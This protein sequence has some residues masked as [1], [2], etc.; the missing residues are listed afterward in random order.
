MVWLD[1]P[2]GFSVSRHMRKVVPI[3]NQFLIYKDRLMSEGLMKDMVAVIAEQ[4]RCGNIACLR[5]KL[6]AVLPLPGEPASKNALLRLGMFLLEHDVALKSGKF[7]SDW[8][9]SP[10]VWVAALVDDVFRDLSIPSGFKAR[11]K[12]RVVALT[13]PPAGLILD[14]C[15]S[16][17]YAAYLPKMV[18]VPARTGKEVLPTDAIGMVFFA[19]FGSTPGRPF[20][21]LEV[22]ASNSMKIMNKQLFNRRHP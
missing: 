2:K 9:G 3:A 12:M 5:T 16:I 10:T 6:L 15:L 7:F 21:M 4:R 14:T 20:T 18:G 11:Y 8:N 19:Q 1:L 13:G 22:Q 17:R